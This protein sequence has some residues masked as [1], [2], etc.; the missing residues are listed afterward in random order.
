M[1]RVGDLVG[2][3]L[4]PFVLGAATAFLLNDPSSHAAAEAPIVAVSPAKFTPQVGSRA[5]TS[6]GRRSPPPVAESLGCDELEQQLATLDGLVQEWFGDGEPWPDDSVPQLDE[7]G[8]AA[9]MEE[10]AMDV[11]GASVVEVD[12][13]RYPCVGVWRV[14]ELDARALAERGEDG[15]GELR[16]SMRMLPIMD[17]KG[18]TTHW[19][20]STSAYA[21]GTADPA[22]VSLRMNAL[23]SASGW[24]GYETVAPE[25][26]E[27]AVPFSE[28]L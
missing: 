16:M 7:P 6:E 3:G 22:L 15:V 25:D 28:E 10:V 9:W 26:P 1:S 13:F 4:L 24:Y 21:P 23:L 19:M 18:G 20:V 8:F 2:W 14:E 17:G 11:P 5:S 27:A 12:C